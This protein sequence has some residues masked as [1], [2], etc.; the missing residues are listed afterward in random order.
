MS[1][2]A[3]A[4]KKVFVPCPDGRHQAVCVDL[5]DMGIDPVYGKPRLRLVFQI[6][7]ADATTG[8][9]YDVALFCN[10]SL[11]EK[12][13][14]RRWLTSWFGRPLLQAELEGF[15]LET[16]IGRNAIVT[17]IPSTKANGDPSAL[18]AALQPCPPDRPRLVPVDYTRAQ[19]RPTTGATPTPAV[20]TP[21]VVASRPPR[22]AP[23]PVG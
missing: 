16:L 8:R 9:R 6:A 20:P 12:A 13:N 7:E 17:V 14:L 23:G 21:P 15:E 1:L 22:P 11:H 18:I 2:I 10:N 3:S 19:D 4:P 5:V